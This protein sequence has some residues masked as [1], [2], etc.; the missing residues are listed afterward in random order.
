MARSK[1]KRKVSGKGRRKDAILK[2]IFVYGLLVVPII[3][4][5][6]FWLMVN[7]DSLLLPFQDNQTGEFTLNNFKVIF[8]SLKVGG[9]LTIAFKNTL[10]YW[11]SG[12]LCQYVLALSVTYF[13][14][15]K[16]F[17]HRFFTFLFMVPSILS[18]VVLVAIYKNLVGSTGPLAV[19]YETL[20]HKTMP[21]LLYSNSTATWTIVVFCVWTG[22]G[23]NVILFSGAMSKIPNEIVEA[24]NLDGAGFFREFLSIELPMI[25]PTVLIMLLFSVSGILMSSGPILLFTG[26]MYETTTISYWFYENVIVNR[27]YGVSSA[28]GLLLSLVAVPLVLIVN[29]ISNKMEVVEY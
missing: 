24:A 1:A 11:A 22:F 25:M 19:I 17:M 6:V 20:F 16:I 21:S 4:F 7:I 9:E 2:H 15:K 13:L 10:I 28:F 3:H 29:R 5:I 14:Y 12:L 8:D 26:G 23:M 18:S 27:D